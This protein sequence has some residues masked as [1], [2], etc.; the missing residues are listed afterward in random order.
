[1]SQ[2]KQVLPFF[3]RYLESQ[4]EDMTAEELNQVSGGAGDIVTQAYPS[5]GDLADSGYPTRKPKDPYS[6]GDFPNFPVNF[7]F[8]SLGNGSNYTK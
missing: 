1:M 3:A 6:I 7:P 8:P 4:A 5:D 2:D